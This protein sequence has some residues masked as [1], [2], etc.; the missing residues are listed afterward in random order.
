MLQI[1]FGVSGPQRLLIAFF[2]VLDSTVWC[3][4]ESPKKSFV[5]QNYT[6]CIAAL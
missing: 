3:K 2:I 5:L 4:G 1:F 6:K